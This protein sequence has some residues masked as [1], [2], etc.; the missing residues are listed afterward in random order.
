MWYVCPHP[1]PHQ[2]VEAARAANAH[3]FISG[4]EDGYKTRVG[5]QAVLYRVFKR[6]KVS[7][8]ADREYQDE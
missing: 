8:L 3:D 7:T 5:E 4:F 1:P 6:V 2:V